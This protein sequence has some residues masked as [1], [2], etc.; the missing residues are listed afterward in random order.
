[1]NCPNCGTQ[2]IDGAK[3]CIKCGGAISS[4]NQQTFGTMTEQFQ[5]QQSNYSQPQQ[6]YNQTSYNQQS[7]QQ[8][9]PNSN[10]LPNMSISEGFF[11]ILAM[12]LK[13]FTAFK[14]ESN[15]FNSFKNSA[16]LALI[17]SLVAT[18]VSLVKTMFSAVRVTSYWSSETK[19]VWENLKEINYIKT[20]GT[21]FL[22]YIGII[23]AIACVY[24]IASLVVKKQ[25]NFSKLLGIAACAVAPMVIC[26][27]IISPLLTMIY[28]PLGMG[29]T[30]VGG[31]YT[32]L[33]TYELINNE[34]QLEGNTKL[35]FNLI[36][37]SI[38]AIAGYYLY[39]KFM[40]G[41]V[42]SSVNNILDMFGY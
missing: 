17:I 37:M 35:Y 41:S 39:M 19:W 2:N 27:L 1:M 7:M 42:S 22:I 36:C 13:P 16:I 12:L 24:Y 29:V 9:I 23:A 6:N 34:I 3:F 15:K 18:V 10:S 31:V 14:Q 30:V 40:M 11:I 21:N 4:S 8:N 38:L 5:S 33:I 20:I 26:S 25:I 32:V 28:A